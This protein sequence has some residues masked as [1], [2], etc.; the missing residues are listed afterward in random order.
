M[1]SAERV[2]RFLVDSDGDKAGA[3]WSQE[4][5]GVEEENTEKV[6]LGTA[7]TEGKQKGREFTAVCAPFWGWGWGACVHAGARVG[8]LADSRSH[9][10]GIW[11]PEHQDSGG[12]SIG[13]GPMWSLLRQAGAWDLGP[14]AAVLAPEQTCP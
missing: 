14:F 7:E 10:P 12:L 8:S 9:R 1:S 6:F 5:M 3:Q 13:R 11:Y 4:R 2:I